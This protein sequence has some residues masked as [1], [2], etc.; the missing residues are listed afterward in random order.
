MP[1][2]G[3]NRI[4]PGANLREHAAENGS[5]VFVK[6]TV[7]GVHKQMNGLGEEMHTAASGTIAEPWPRDALASRR[8]VQEQLATILELRW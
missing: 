7:C 3:A 2:I 8:E 6:A 1:L 4:R 5:A